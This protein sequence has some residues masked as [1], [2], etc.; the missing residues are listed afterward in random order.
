MS[1][2]NIGISVVLAKAFILAFCFFVGMP[3]GP[4]ST[5]LV[6]SDDHAK[7]LISAVYTHTQV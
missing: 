7:L 3:R 5:D 6:I 1:S 2:S 4:I